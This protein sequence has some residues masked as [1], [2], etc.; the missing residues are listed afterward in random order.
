MAEADAALATRLM[1]RDESALREVVETYGGMVNGMARKVL[2]D[3][4]LAEEVAQ[5]TFLAL[6]RRPGAFD[7]ARGSLKTFLA[8]IARNKAIDLVRKE[9]SAKRAKDALLHEFSPGADIMRF[10]SD[11]EERSKV[12]S[13]L[14][15]LSQSQRHAIVL[16]YYGGRTYRE[17]ADEL[18]VPEG[19]I[20]T[21]M[22]DG[23]AKLR[24]MLI[25][26]TESI[27]DE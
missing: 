9:E 27:D 18:R 4:S 26:S 19:T 3:P 13:V 20:K 7:P 6:W 24:R 10:E 1:S 14:S 17:V 23:L 11:V 22:R 12:V 8:S 2:A 25:E 21:R 15:G 16:A 5:D